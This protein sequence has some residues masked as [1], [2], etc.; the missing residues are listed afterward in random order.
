VLLESSVCGATG[1]AATGKIAD[2]LG[3]LREVRRFQRSISAESLRSRRRASTSPRTIGEDGHR[4]AGLLELWQPAPAAR[5]SRSPAGSAAQRAQNGTRRMPGPRSVSHQ[6]AQL[7]F[8]E[9]HP[10]SLRCSNS[11]PPARWSV[12]RHAASRSACAR[13][14]IPAAVRILPAQLE[15][16][17]RLDD[18]V[19]VLEVALAGL[20]SGRGPRPRLARLGGEDRHAVDHGQDPFHLDGRHDQKRE[21]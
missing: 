9:P 2:D 11:S 17:Q 12:A 21:K 18:C 13:A 15:V 5:R 1:S 3:A 14:V 6:L 10:L 19:P 7:P 20:P 4:F 16:H 8:P